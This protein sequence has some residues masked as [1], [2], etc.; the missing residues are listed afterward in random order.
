MKTTIFLKYF[1]NDRLWKQFFAS[2]SPQTPS[3]LPCLTIFKR[4][5]QSF[6]LI[7]QQLFFKKALK[8]VLLDIYFRDLYT[9]FEI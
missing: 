1:M 4:L 6:K 5:W 9:E 3:N 2:K 8:L 7:L